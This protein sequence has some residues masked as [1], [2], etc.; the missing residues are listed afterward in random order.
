MKNVGQHQEI[1]SAQKIGVL[2][3]MALFILVG[4]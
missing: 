3:D 4:V 1:N 2:R